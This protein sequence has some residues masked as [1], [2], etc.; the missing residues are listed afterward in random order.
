MRKKILPIGFLHSFQHTDSAHDTLLPLSIIYTVKGF[1][2]HAKTNMYSHFIHILDKKQNISLT[3]RVGINI[4]TKQCHKNRFNLHCHLWMKHLSRGKKSAKF[5]G[6]WRN[7]LIKPR[8]IPTNVFYTFCVLLL[9]FSFLI[10][11]L[12]HHSFLK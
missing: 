10:F 6:K 11:F 2:F 12:L 1:P 3:V 9:D 4:L 8:F 5:F 7:F